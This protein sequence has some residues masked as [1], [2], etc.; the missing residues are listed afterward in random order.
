[1]RYFCLIF[2][3]FIGLYSPIEL[4]AQN[5]EILSLEAFFERAHTENFTGRIIRGLSPEHF[6]RLSFNPN[7]RITFLIG[8]DGF[9][10][11]DGKNGY[12]M[13]KMIGYPQAF[14]ENICSQGYLFKIIA[15]TD[16]LDTKLATWENLFLLACEAY[17]EFASDFLTHENALTLLE[18]ED[19]ESAAGYK[20]NDVKSAGDKDARYMTYERYSK[21]SRNLLETRAFFYF[22][23][24]LN[25]LF[26]GDG[27]TYDEEGNRRFKE[28]FVLNKNLSELDLYYLINL[29]VEI[30]TLLET[31]YET[32][33][34]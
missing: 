5:K 24:G 30:P 1:M 2:F 9:D 6:E 10:M 18:F 22:T 16:T 32:I 11:L 13:L 14:I 31:N 19:F 28:Y 21:S 4:S 25:K 23:L 12:E 3:V 33:E 34:L 27:Y 20:F 26:S 17:S 15:F 8:S 7:C 29:D